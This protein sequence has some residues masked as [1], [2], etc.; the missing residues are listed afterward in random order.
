MKYF[1]DV[2]LPY[3]LN[4]LTYSV[5]DGL[6]GKVFIGQSVSVGLG[7]NK[8][9][10]GIVVRIF[11]VAPS[12]EVKPIESVTNNIPAVN[13]LHIDF[14]R[15]IA[16]Y[17]MCSMGEVM[18][19][20]LPAYLKMERE[21][22]VYA[23]EF[24]HLND[25]SAVEET[26]LRNVE[27]NKTLAIADLAR[28]MPKKNIYTVVQAL[29]S[30]KLLFI[31]EDQHNAYK[32]LSV[33]KVFLSEE[34]C[35]ILS[36]NEFIALNQKK[37]PKQSDLLKGI[38]QMVMSGKNGLLK[39]DISEKDYFSA[40]S[41]QSLLEKGILR[42]SSEI[43]A[44][45]AQEKAIDEPLKQLNEYQ[46]D[47][48]DKINHNIQ[49]KRPVLLHGVTS[50]GKTEVYLHLIKQVIGQE[51]QVLYLLPEIGLTS[52]IISRIN[53]NFGANSTVYHSGLSTSEKYEIWKALLDTNATNLK[54]I[55]G[56][57]SAIFLPFTNL[58]LIIVD[59]EHEST[60][61][62]TEP[63]PRYNARDMALVLAQM[64]KCG[65][66]LGSATPSVESY[67]NAKTGKFELVEISKRFDS[68][69]LPIVEIIDMR[70]KQNQL[71]N[72]V[73]SPIMLKKVNDALEKKEQIILFRN[74]RGFSPILI[75]ADCG[76]IPKCKNC[77]VS[78]TYHKEDN[79][80]VCHYCGY[81]HKNTGKCSYCGK[82]NLNTVG[83]GTQKLEEEIQ[84][85]FKNAKVARVD[86]DSMRKKHAYKKLFDDFEAQ[87]I[88]IL[89]GTQI[90]AKGLD[91]KHVN[92]VGV[93]SVDALSS[94]A[95]FRANERA[96][97]LLTQ[98]SGRAGRHKGEG[99]VI[100]QAYSTENKMLGFVEKADFI[101]FYN[102]EISER[103]EFMYPPFVKL[104]KIE[105]R[106]NLENIA[107]K[108]AQTLVLAL[109]QKQDCVVL[110][111]I[112]PYIKRV[113]NKYNLQI[114]IKLKRSNHLHED[115]M[116]VKKIL[117]IMSKDTD[118]KSVQYVV[119][120]DPY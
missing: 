7:K 5:P 81:S 118:I 18:N 42:E 1:V 61:K 22:R 108:A 19:A 21:T 52:Q 91:F 39:S 28:K 25:L 26:I 13:Q 57:R 115:K 86:T 114:L 84:F 41:Y 71:K 94:M 90:L 36:V 74:R 110:G 102:N 89:V 73:F 6:D 112:Y 97:Q 66:V 103:Q 55:V 109:Q 107:Q 117:N 35:N 27:Q 24:K 72:S 10:N 32:E 63:A 29:L 59:E 96:Y 31:L 58:G 16:D 46:Q 113:Q 69:K 38:F 119:D 62:Q 45:Y 105:V 47:A 17:Y 23:S 15:W 111:P 120:V 53:K 88:D 80:L 44:R 75:C 101:S 77:D 4:E 67:F 116:F 93:L 87:K 82:T 14:W 3:K 78:L 2:V 95:D 98:V 12:F 104:I 48:Y 43:K 79:Q 76:A 99:L 83:Y 100:M 30:R 33:K 92:T 50:S 70:L 64:H 65:I 8:L 20:A 56:V 34:Y 40:S 9:L 68:Q 11:S 60:F 49:Q 37:A 106:H 51:K 85:I 54:L